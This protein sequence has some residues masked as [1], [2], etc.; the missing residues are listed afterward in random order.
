[1]KFM[2]NRLII[3]TLPLALAG[4]SNGTASAQSRDE[5]PYSIMR[6]EPGSRPARRVAPRPKQVAPAVNEATP[7]QAQKAGPRPVRRGSSYSNTPVY[8]SP[9]T[10]LGQ[11]PRVGNVQPLGQPASPSMIVPGIQSNTGPAMTPPRPA[12]QSFQDRTIN[13]VQ[14]GSA[15]GVGPGQIG[16]FTR[17]C[18]NQ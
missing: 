12:G 5:F 8:Q 15:S 16:G 7:R 10:P 17:N 13:C 14:S 3:L 2:R 1:M 4:F 18:V 6:E 11:A 9:V